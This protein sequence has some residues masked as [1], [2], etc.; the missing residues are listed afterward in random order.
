MY[1]IYNIFYK[2]V[3]IYILPLQASYRHHDDFAKKSY[4]FGLGIQKSCSTTACDLHILSLKLL[5]RF[6]LNSYP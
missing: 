1:N 3:Y 6:F 5:M 4:D 2:Y